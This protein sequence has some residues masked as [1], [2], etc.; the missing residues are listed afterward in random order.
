MKSKEEYLASIYKK[1]DREINKQ[2]KRISAITS[3]ICLA[4]CFAAVFAFVPK[5]FGTKSIISE[6]VNGNGNSLTKTEI[7]TLNQ[8]IYVLTNDNANIYNGPDKTI[9]GHTVKTNN[10]EDRL[11]TE[12]AV[13]AV[14][15]QINFGYVGEPFDPDLLLRPSSGGTIE[16]KPNSHED[17]YITGVSEPCSE[18]PD[19]AEK[20]TVK[21]TSKAAIRSSGEATEEALKYVPEDDRQNINK[22]KTQVTITKKSGGKSTYNVYFYT[23]SKTYTVELNAVTLELIEFREKNINTGNINRFS[24]AHFPETTAALPEYIPE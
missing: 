18:L 21:S 10:E 24:P 19:E 17:E 6:S 22:E 13:E 3:I 11:Q 1:R 12:I 20:L 23:E 14:T 16:T 5:K 8:E 9:D 2:R 7:T 15:R 4:V